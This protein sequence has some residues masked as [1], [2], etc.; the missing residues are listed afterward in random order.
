MTQTLPIKYIEVIFLF[1][2]KIHALRVDWREY[3]FLCGLEVGPVIA[4][5]TRHF[6]GVHTSG[7]DNVTVG[8]ADSAIGCI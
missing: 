8:D 5:P 3:L 7:Q 4:C 2:V 6:A 1:C